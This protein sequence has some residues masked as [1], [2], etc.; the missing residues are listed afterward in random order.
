VEA[1]Q[2][3][4]EKETRVETR[5]LLEQVLARLYQGESFSAAIG[6]HPQA[7]PAL[8]VASVR[9]AE[10]TSNLSEALGRYVAYQAQVE[11]VRNKIVAAAVYPLLLLAVG[12]LVALFLLGWV[13][14]RF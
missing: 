13:V 10:R 6:H 12:G 4:S 9:A 8:Y 3:L 11:R 14:P 2:S 1:L 7:F 5:R